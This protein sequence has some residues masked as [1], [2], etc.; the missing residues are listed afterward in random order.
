MRL[1]RDAWAIHDAVWRPWRTDVRKK[2]ACAAHA[3]AGSSRR[4]GGRRSLG[5]SRLF[6]QTRATGCVP[7]LEGA[8]LILLSL[9]DYWH[10]QEFWPEIREEA[11]G[12]SPRRSRT[13]T[14]RVRDTLPGIPP[15]SHLE[16]VIGVH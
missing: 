16:Q 11:V 2:D 1:L 7:V 10:A 12:T 13:C 3:V 15:Q 6:V 8:A 9:G 14:A 4:R 5:R